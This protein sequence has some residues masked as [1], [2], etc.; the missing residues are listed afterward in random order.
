M[1]ATT[2]IRKSNNRLTE[3]VLRALDNYLAFTGESETI[4][5]ERILSLGSSELQRVCNA[6]VSNRDVVASRTVVAQAINSHSDVRER[7]ILQYMLDN[8]FVPP[9]LKLPF[10][11]ATSLDPRI[12]FTRADATT[13]ATLFDSTGRLQ[14]VAANVPRFDYDPATPAGV[15]GGELVT[16]GDFSNGSNSWTLDAAASVSGGQLVLGAGVATL[17]CQQTIPITIGKT[18]QITFDLVSIVGEGVSFTASSGSYIGTSRTVAGRYSQ[19][20]VAVTSSLS[21][22]GIRARGA[23]ITSAVIDN[24]SVQE[25]TFSPRGLLIEESRANLLLQSRDMTNA[26]W[27]K[28]DVTPARTQ[29]GLDGA[30]NTACLM[31]EGSAGT[32]V[33]SQTGAAVT[34]GST[35]TASVVLKRGN[36]DWFRIVAQEPTAVDGAAAWFNLATG[37]KGTVVAKGAGTNNSSTITSLGGGWYRCTVTTTPN[38]SYTS[39]QVWVISASADNSGTRVSG[40]TYIVD[41]A[42]LE[43]GSFATSIIPTTTTS[44]TRAADSASMTGTNFSSWFNASAGTFAADIQFGGTGAGGAT[45]IIQADDGTEAN[46]LVMAATNAL[47]RI[48]DTVAGVSQADYSTAYTGTTSKHTFAYQLNDIGSAV[49]GTLGAGDTSCT[50]PTVN[51]LRIGSAQAGTYGQIWLRGL[52]F[53]ATR[54][55]AATVTALST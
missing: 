34:A 40:A 45:R 26:S 39:P 42:Q 13:C 36:N 35:I 18:Y 20:I 2:Y 54:L 51:L 25:V 41:C 22:F 5:R 7:R 52:S 44:L 4:V 31:T 37:A 8:T 29:V 38:A 55:P 6:L 16:N 33:L 11:G 48:I 53:Y 19:N 14:T 32:A 30:A 27:T 9:A 23:G 1:V 12:T 28:T 21:F 43:V 15:T 46:R 17:Y 50:L 10:A 47:S 3:S 49:N 24:I